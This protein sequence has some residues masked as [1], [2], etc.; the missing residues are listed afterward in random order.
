[1][2]VL[3]TVDIRFASWEGEQSFLDVF[4]QL[5]R[6]IKGI[7]GCL[8]YRVYRGPDRLYLFFVVW[9]DREAVQRWVENEFHQTVLMKN[10]RKW[11]KEGWFG[12]WNPAG[13]RLRAR[14]CMHCGRWTQA[15]PGWSMEE[16]ARCRQCGESVLPGGH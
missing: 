12:Y 4:Q 7:A 8:E 2:A 9:Q 6:E 14:R 10:F 3:T 5:E 1:M 13:D 15:Q 11:C 16:P